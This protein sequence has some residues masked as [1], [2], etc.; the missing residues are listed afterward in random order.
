MRNDYELFYETELC[1]R[2]ASFNKS[3][4]P[5]SGRDAALIQRRLPRLKSLFQG[6][7]MK[8]FLIILSEYQKV[9]QVWSGKVDYWQ[10]GG[11]MK[12][13]KQSLFLTLVLAVFTLSTSSSQVCAEEKDW[14]K[15]VE[16]GKKRHKEDFCERYPDHKVC[17]EE[18]EPKP[19]PKSCEDRFP[20][21]G[22]GY[23]NCMTQ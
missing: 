7:K 5:T 12:I 19:E 4:Q 18:S 1:R 2:A 21:L 22:R 14:G 3:L 8:F 20:N 16:E 6:L 17:V 13:I 11:N 15:S 10:L 9:A 23:K